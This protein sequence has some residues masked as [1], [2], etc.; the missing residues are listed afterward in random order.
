AGRAAGGTPGA[1]PALA[2]RHGGSSGAR[3]EEL[4][5]E[6]SGPYDARDPRCLE[7]RQR[8]A[9]N[10]VFDLLRRRLGRWEAAHWQSE[11]ERRP[12]APG[13]FPDLIVTSREYGALRVRAIYRELLGRAAEEGEVERF[14]QRDPREPREYLEWAGSRPVGLALVLSAEFGGVPPSAGREAYERWTRAW[15]AR[16]YVRLLGRPAS[17]HELASASARLRHERDPRRFAEDLLGSLEY[18][19]GLVRRVWEEDLQGGRL[20]PAEPGGTVERWAGF[21][22]D[23]NG[24]RDTLVARL[25]ATEAYYAGAMRTRA[26][27]CPVP[28]EDYGPLDTC[29]GSASRCSYRGWIPDS[30]EPWPG[31]ARTGLVVRQGGF[32][33]WIATTCEL[34]QRPVAADQPHPGDVW[35]EPFPRE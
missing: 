16:L 31:T 2:A 23:G 30:G 33:G 22:Y 3:G 15:P 1:A 11:S 28:L 12:L 4:D 13:Q 17:E 32:G 24:D 29:G 8:F 35:C 26:E 21:L 34:G 18:H 25:A 10:V 20:D 7:Y 6:D 5:R 9:A 27:V 14:L 19:R